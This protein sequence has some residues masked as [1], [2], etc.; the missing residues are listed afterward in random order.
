MS[1]RRLAVGLASLAFVAS[2]GWLLYDG[3]FPAWRC[4]DVDPAILAE[5]SVSHGEYLARAAGC[6]S[7]HTDEE[8]RGAYLAGGRAL[9]TPFGTFYAPNITPDPETGIGRWTAGDFMCAMRHGIGPDGKH[10]YP[11][12]PYTSYTQMR[13]ADVADI[14]VYLR[15][16]RPEHRRDR[17][18]ELPWYL[19]SRVA[20]WGWKTLFFEPGEFRPD[21]DRLPEWN[22]GAYLTLAVGHCSECHTPRGRFGRP[23]PSR[24]L[25]GT[26]TGPDGKVVPNIT[27]SRETGIGRWTADDLAYFLKT[28]MTPEGDFAGGAMSEVID[29]SLS[30]LNDRDVGAL[31]TYLR[32]L[33]AVDHAVRPAKRKRDEFDY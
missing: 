7:C 4:E 8:T 27:P 16:A 33:P 24:F 20:A 22:R 2:G 11:A 25:A 12:F 30:H 26:K 21:E 18:H 5:A 13:E 9:K 14:Y 3:V 28:G 23:D 32:E 31:V 10:Y 19:W 29:N 15:T 6:S 1:A 17:S